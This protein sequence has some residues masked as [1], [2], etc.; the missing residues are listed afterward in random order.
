LTTIDLTEEHLAAIRW[1]AER[2]PEVSHV[3]LFGSQG[4]AANFTLDA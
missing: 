3:V 1:W 4:G 2:T